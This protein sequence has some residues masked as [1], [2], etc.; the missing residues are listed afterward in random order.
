MSDDNERWKVVEGYENYE[1]SDNG[2]VR[3]TQTGKIIKQRSDKDGYLRLNISK[4][5]KQKT[6]SV[7]RIVAEAF[8]EKKDGCI[9]VDHINNDKTDNRAINLRWVTKSENQRNCVRKNATGFAG[10]WKTSSGKFAAQCTNKEG[11]QIHLG[12]RDTPEEAHALYKEYNRECG[13][14]IY[15]LNINVNIENYNDNSTHNNV[16]HEVE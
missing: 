15:R 7:H 11:K 16:V 6:M 3:N 14:V 4:D 9:E 5:K 13:A 10:V 2:N 1:V 12:C 8:C